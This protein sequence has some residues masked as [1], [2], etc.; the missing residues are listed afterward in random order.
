MRTKFNTLFIFGFIFL[1]LG[2]NFLVSTLT[3]VIGFTL[4]PY[5]AG[6][7]IVLFFLII[8]HFFDFSNIS[9]FNLILLGLTVAF[10]SFI[11][12]RVFDFIIFNNVNN[13]TLTFWEWYN[14]PYTGSMFWTLFKVY[15]YSNLGIDYVQE[16]FEFIL[17]TYLSVSF[18][19][20]LNNHEHWEWG[21]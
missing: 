18:S 5:V 8:H 2:I 3:S 11:G 6:I 12:S 9:S 20:N 1:I 17:L 14:L 10:L 19:K 16:G 21:K 13:L 15:D 7:Q 4:W